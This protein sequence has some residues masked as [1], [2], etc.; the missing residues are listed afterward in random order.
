MTIFTKKY[1]DIIG[2][3]DDDWGWTQLVF[4]KLFEQQLVFDTTQC[5]QNLTK[6]TET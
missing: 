2:L 6:S 3:V 4:E 5:F 1:D